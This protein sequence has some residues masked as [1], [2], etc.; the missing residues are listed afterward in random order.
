MHIHPGLAGVG[1]LGC[2]S[3]MAWLLFAI[4]YLIVRRE[5]INLIDLGMSVATVVIVVMLVVPDNF[6]A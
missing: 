4:P 2:L 3:L 5:I 6:F 1:L